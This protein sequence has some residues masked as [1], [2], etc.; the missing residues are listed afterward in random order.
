[1][2]LLVAASINPQ[3]FKPESTWSPFAKDDGTAFYL[4]ASDNGDVFEI[5]A[6][7]DGAGGKGRIEHLAIPAA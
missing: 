6:V 3:T 1:M 2:R 7:R 4:R 5:K